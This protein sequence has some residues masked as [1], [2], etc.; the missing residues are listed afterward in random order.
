MLPLL[1]LASVVAV[2]DLVTS[3]PVLA[4]DLEY[5]ANRVKVL[6][7]ILKRFARGDFQEAGDFA[8]QAEVVQNLTYEYRQQQR[9]LKRLQE[10][11]SKA[12]DASLAEVASLD[13]LVGA[14]QAQ[15][16]SL[17][18]QLR[19]VTT[20]PS[21]AEG[22]SGLTPTGGVGLDGFTD[23]LLESITAAVR[24]LGGKLFDVGQE[25]GDTVSAGA[26]SK[27]LTAEDFAKSLREFNRG[28]QGELAVARASALGT[29]TEDVIK[30]LNDQL[31]ETEK[32]NE[33]I[34]RTQKE[35]N[36]AI[37]KQ[38]RFTQTDLL[39]RAQRKLINADLK[40]GEKGPP[41]PSHQAA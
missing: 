6:I 25:I 37:S 29:G 5:F 24:S 11:R 19:A 9:E 41:G 22:L 2:E 36:E 14:A 33:A 20:G 38:V 21:A 28:F 13:R 30:F 17:K 16:D 40:Q 26:V 12:T 18:A 4:A 27:L 39:L 23:D 15:L 32:K 3:L 35:I 34:L 31:V 7:G 1:I 10:R 8:A